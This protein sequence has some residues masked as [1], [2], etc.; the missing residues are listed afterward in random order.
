MSPVSGF[1]FGFGSGRGW[2]FW[3][4]R[5]FVIQ[6]GLDFIRLNWMV[7]GTVI[8]LDVGIRSFL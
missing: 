7:Q 1:G 6:I 3:L 8:E 2:T 4:R 5:W